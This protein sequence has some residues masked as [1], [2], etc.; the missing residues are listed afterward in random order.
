MVFVLA[1]S[2]LGSRAF[3]AEECPGGMHEVKWGTECERC[4]DDILKATGVVRYADGDTGYEVAY[5]GTQVTRMERRI[6][7]EPPTLQVVDLASGARE[8]SE[9][10]GVKLAL[11]APSPAGLR[12][13]DE[14]GKVA[15]I[16]QFWG[17]RQRNMR[18]LYAML[19]GTWDV[20]GA[21]RYPAPGAHMRGHWTDGYYHRRTLGYWRVTLENGS[22]ENGHWGKGEPVGL[23]TVVATD[24]RVVE[25]GRYDSGYPNGRWTCEADD[26]AVTT[27][28]YRLG[29]QVGD[30]VTVDATGAVV[31]TV[32]HREGE[33]EYAVRGRHWRGGMLASARVRSPCD[34]HPQSVLTM[35][36]SAAVPPG[37]VLLRIMDESELGL[38]G[39]LV[40]LDGSAQGVVTDAE[41]RVSLGP[42]APGAHLL[43]ATKP[44][45]GKIKGRFTVD[46]AP[47]TGVE[48]DVE[49]SYGGTFY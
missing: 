46:E 27:G 44:G 28:R 41:G 17:W 40:T 25:R 3:A 15:I 7:G 35:M 23:W 43:E 24:G 5:A 18:N 48:A 10:C 30:W 32:T 39:V 12:W 13:L 8:S 36:P 26:G 29:R 11:P 37:M 2:L 16:E 9:V 49:M 33:A 45:F 22:V 34:P 20:V 47:A 6:Q 42:M 1:L 14:T 21:R 31:S 38:P 19:D 4:A